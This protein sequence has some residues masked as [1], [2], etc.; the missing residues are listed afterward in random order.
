MPNVSRQGRTSIGARKPIREI[1]ACLTVHM[2]K[3]V[4][5]TCTLDDTPEH[6]SNA[7]ASSKWASGVW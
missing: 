6:V 5:C 2:E 4:H 3:D 7:I 1:R